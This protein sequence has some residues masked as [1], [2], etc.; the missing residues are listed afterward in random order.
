MNFKAILFYV[1]IFTY[2]S[3]TAQET[4]SKKKIDS[5]LYNTRYRVSVYPKHTFSEFKKLYSASLK[6]N[7]KIGVSYSLI[8]MGHS[9]SYLDNFKNAISYVKK[10]R[11]IANQI[12]NDS[13]LLYADFVDCLQYGSMHMNIKAVNM[14]NNC[15][16]RI[17]VL[18]DKESK[19]LMLGSL[20]T[21]K[22][23]FSAGLIKKPSKEEYLFLHR[24]AFYHFNK[25]KRLLSNPSFINLGNCFNTLNQLDSA[26]YYYQKGVRFAKL[27]GKTSEIE[28]INLANLHIKRKEYPVAL[29]Y[30]DSSITICEKKNIY[31]LLSENY[32]LY[33]KIHTQ[34]GN[35]DRALVSHDLFLKY[36]D[37]AE[38]LERNRVVESVNFLFDASSNENDTLLKRNKT[39]IIVSLLF[40]IGLAIL[41]RFL[42]LK[43]KYLKGES[44][45]K[46]IELVEKTNQI[47]TLK[48]KVSTSYNE[49][50]EMAKKNDPLFLPMFKELYPEFYDRLIKIQPD[51]TITEQKVCFYLKLKF[52]TKEIADYTFVTT[53]AI[54][55]RKNRLR[56]RLHLNDGD[57]LYLWIDTL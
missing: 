55:N 45:I 49:V 50:I 7:Y 11:E 24:K 28:Y 38:I 16:N 42:Y 46:E 53:K 13:L 36:K 43:R 21:C 54:Q 41:S 3:V 32:S 27:K 12:N 9:E 1:F 44:L 29:K 56:K 34:L 6:E 20:Y 39:I 52:S 14:I 23:N 35:K 48:Q 33:T 4:F 15:I 18:N 57:D 26:K 51:L 8:G 47:V 19:H 10:G 30:L 40:V 5:L 2:F 25:V 17:D 22:A 37:S 31:Y